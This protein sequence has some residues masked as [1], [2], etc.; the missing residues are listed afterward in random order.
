VARRLGQHFLARR[1]ILEKIARAACPE[2]SPL[3]IEIGAGRGALTAHLLDRAERVVAIEIDP[4]LVA[5]LRQKFRENRR[6]TVL[7]RD[8]LKTDFAQWGPAVIA[9]NLPYYITSPILERLFAAGA[10]WVRAVFL[11]QK[12]VGARLTAAPGA[13]DYGF[14][15]VAA[16]IFSI[17]EFLFTVSAS[18]FRP[19]PKVESGVIRLARRDPAADWGLDDPADFLSFASLCFTQKR[20]MLRN[21]LRARYP[22]ID[23]LPQA[24][25]RGEQLSVPD[26]IALYRRLT[27]GA[28]IEPPPCDTLAQ[29]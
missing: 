3:V 22:Q 6:I 19:P 20:K 4:V 8:I 11:V 29:Q 28:A 10:A 24:S 17:P 2:P 14:L 25:L 5:Y 15:T 23:A 1:S 7:E 12:E 13:R 27:R 26:L 18:A 9:G 21:N 16:Q